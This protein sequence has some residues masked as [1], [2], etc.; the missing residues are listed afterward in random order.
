[1]VG[2]G[3]MIFHATLLYGAQLADE[4][5]MIYV[6]TYCSAMLFDTDSGF[7]RTT[8]TATIAAIYI[9]FNV[10]FTWS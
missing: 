5:P 1:M 8:K 7:A 4:L 6:A 2:L 10:L 3:S 9:L